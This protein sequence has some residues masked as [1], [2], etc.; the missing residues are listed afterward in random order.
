MKRDQSICPNCGSGD[1]EFL[2]R[3]SSEHDLFAGMPAAN[4]HC[5]VC[6]I[7]WEVDEIDL[8]T[9]TA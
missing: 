2:L 5:H 1:V 6:G 7:L 3:Q 8:E 9:Q 4:R